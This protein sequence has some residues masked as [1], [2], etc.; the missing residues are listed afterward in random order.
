MNNEKLVLRPKRNKGEDG[1]KVF[2]I[3]VSEE[4]LDEINEISA[5]T[6]Y[7][8][9]EIINRFLNYALEQCVISYE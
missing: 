9:N 7:S 2:S 4:L 6:G 8:R 1:Y 5:K 3:R